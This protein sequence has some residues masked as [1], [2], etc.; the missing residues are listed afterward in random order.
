M[1]TASNAT[2]S[3]PA[4]SGRVSRA[5]MRITVSNTVPAASADRAN[6]QPCSPTEVLLATTGPRTEMAPM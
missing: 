6:P 5:R 1:G 3:I 4:T 2:P